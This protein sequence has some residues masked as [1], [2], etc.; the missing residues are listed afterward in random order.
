MIFA[1]PGNEPFAQ[2]LADELRLPTGSIESRSFPDHESYIRVES[3]VKDSDIIIVCSQ[4][5][6]NE[7]LLPLLFTINALKEQGAKRVALV[8]PYLAYMRQDKIFKR[9]ESITSKFYASLLS[10]HIDFLFTI[11]P[12]LHR[13]HSLSEIY[14]VP[15]Y[16]VASAPAMAEYIKKTFEKILLI[17]TES[18]SRQWVEEIADLAGCRYDILQKIR[19]GDEEVQISPPHIDDNEEVLLVDDI[20]SSGATMIKVASLIRA[21]SKNTRVHALAVHAVFDRASFE[22]VMTGL[23]S[24]ATC[25]TIIHETNQ[26]DLAPL[27]GPVIKEN[28]IV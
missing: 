2:S 13:F 19:F 21:A 3:N 14:S 4:H 26:V 10:E 25:N 5:H 8:A 15:A 23:D 1:L 12:H 6:P 22:K 27:L 18:E 9:G 11:D 28:F 17:G 24:I 16:T 20:I 7:K